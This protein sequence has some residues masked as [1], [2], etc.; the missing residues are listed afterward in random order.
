MNVKVCYTNVTATRS[1]PIQLAHTTADVTLGLQGMVIMETVQVRACRRS[2]IPDG[3]KTQSKL[4]S[5]NRRKVTVDFKGNGTREQEGD[6]KQFAAKRD[7]TI[8]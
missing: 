4:I 3:I 2:P 8:V 5:K 7:I 6:R 1:A